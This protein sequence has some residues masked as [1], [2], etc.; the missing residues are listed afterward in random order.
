MD[1]FAGSI[2]W[3]KTSLPAD[4]SV[5]FSGS[6]QCQDRSAQGFAKPRVSVILRN[7]ARGSSPRSRAR[8]VGSGC[9]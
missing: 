8:N 3:E 7:S 5:Q 6:F 1:S 4:F 2:A 9:Y